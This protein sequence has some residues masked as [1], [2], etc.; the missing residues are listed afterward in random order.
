MAKV[1]RLADYRRRRTFIGFDRHELNLLLTLY[2]RRVTRGE[3]RDYAIDHSDG[4]ALFSVFHH[5]D[6]QPVFEIVKFA[7][8]SD[9]RGD[10]MVSS[11]RRTVERG[12]SLAEVLTVFDRQLQ[13]VSTGN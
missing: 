5:A 2:S 8:G 13:L 1:F 6:D 7:P 9:L 10:F 12:R 11:G 3:W 4:K